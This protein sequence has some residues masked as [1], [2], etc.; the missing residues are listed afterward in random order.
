[1]LQTQGGRADEKNMTT[2]H[3]EYSEERLEGL[4]SPVARR[5]FFRVM[6]VMFRF[7]GEPELP[8][9]VWHDD[10]PHATFPLS[11]CDRF[12]EVLEKRVDVDTYR[13]FVASARFAVPMPTFVGRSGVLGVYEGLVDGYRWIFPQGDWE[14][15]V[16]R[17]RHRCELV[18]TDWPTRIDPWLHFFDLSLT[19]APGVIELASD[20]LVEVEQLGHHSARFVISVHSEPKGVVHEH[21]HRRL[22]IGDVSRAVA[23]EINNPLAIIASSIQFAEDLF[24]SATEGAR[25]EQADGKVTLDAKTWEAL[26]EALTQGREAL[27]DARH[28]VKRVTTFVGS[29]REFAEALEADGPR[30]VRLNHALQHVLEVSSAEFAGLR[31]LICDLGEVPPVRVEGSLQQV[32]YGLL[33]NAAA[34]SQNAP[35]QTVWVRT[36]VEGDFGVVEVEDHGE[37]FA[38]EALE[39]CIEPFFSTH[40]AGEGSGLGLTVANS[41]AQASGGRLEFGTSDGI[42]IVRVLLPVLDVP[43]S[44]EGDD[45]Q[46]RKE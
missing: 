10:S 6:N 20:S 43:N 16:D 4:D 12:L 18:V 23:H 9:P 38:P 40:P 33:K 35:E 32:I 11:Q 34:A 8:E 45:Q 17:G 28:G 7:L 27:D 14:L 42:T 24:A 36:Y 5:P 19:T 30:V 13:A 41:V 29:L 46:N 22:A 3:I 31:A 37:G 25:F 39:R 15:E 1:L 26:R 44:T 2:D 21:L